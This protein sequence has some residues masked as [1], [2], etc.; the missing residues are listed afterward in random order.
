MSYEQESPNAIQVEM[1]EGCNLYCNF[2]GLQ[3]IR[4]KGKHDF[5]FLTVGLAGEIADRIAKAGWTS[6][7]E[8]AMHGEPTMNPNCA[9]IIATFRYALPKQSI[10]VTSNGGGLL[11][12]DLTLNVDT[13]FKAGLN[14]LLLDNYEYVNIVP[15]IKAQY[16]G[17]HMIYE[18]PS[19]AEANPHHRRKPDEHDIVVVQDISK[20]DAGTHS[21]LNNHSGAAFPPNDKGVGKR[22]AKPFRELSIRWDGNVALCCN[23]WRGVYK[24]G[25]VQDYATITELWNHERFYAARQKLVI[26]ERDFG[27]CK[28][29]DAM[30]YR[31]GLLPDKY[32]KETMPL[33]D[34]TTQRILDEAC[35]GAPLTQ[36]VLRPWEL[37]VNGKPL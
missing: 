35:A 32:G 30:S 16:T 36:P 11:K 33:P 29:C 9:A 20:A 19:N 2:C 22:C 15:K 34:A 3:G 25:R 13:L 24:I 31:V 12:G 18:Y 37:T 7:I 23:E 28:G 14:V 17:E 1:T 4:E 21:V 10:M 27:E 5:K 6:R 26:G 8:F